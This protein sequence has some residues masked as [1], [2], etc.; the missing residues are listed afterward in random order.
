MASEGNFVVPEASFDHETPN[1]PDSPCS[2]VADL[3][4]V[5]VSVRYS[6]YW[7]AVTTSDA[8]FL[9]V[10]LVARA[11]LDGVELPGVTYYGSCS[12]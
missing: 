12:S 6:I 7:E 4:G 1:E 8:T 5:P 3:E 9:G 11:T 2:C 10:A